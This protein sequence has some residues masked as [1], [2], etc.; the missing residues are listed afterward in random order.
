MTN[1]CIFI[2]SRIGATRLPKKPI[3]MIG[4]KPMICHVIDR[5]KQ[6][7]IG[8]VV[9]AT[10]SQEI[11]QIVENYNTKCV[12]TDISHQSGSDRVFD[13]LEQV[14]PDKKLE[15]VINLQ[16]DMPF[17]HTSSIK[18]LH[19]FDQ[20]SQADINSL[21]TPITDKERMQMH[22]VVTAVVS[23]KDQDKK[24]GQALYFSREAIPHNAGTYYEHLGIYAFKRDALKKFIS[25]P[26]TNLELQERL[27]QLRALENGMTINVAVVNDS[28]ISV[29]TQEDLDMAI[30]YFERNKGSL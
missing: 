20:K 8:E 12:M 4:N 9:V 16:G 10:D 28:P 23:F 15:F 26:Q 27:E 18:A 1:T 6:A 11:L 25:M 13:A 21:V 7:D 22:S 29:D 14:D 24:W 17:I 30:G 5:A 19:Q 3:L 2:P